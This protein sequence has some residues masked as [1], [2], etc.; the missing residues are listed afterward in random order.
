M[1][2]QTLM[3]SVIPLTN[4]SER[5]TIPILKLAFFVLVFIAVF[6]SL[7]SGLQEDP[8]VKN[9]YVQQAQAF[10]QGRLDLNQYF[11]DTAV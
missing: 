5:R 3:G 9:L 6:G 4:K 11:Y 8:G 7:W 10:L 2:I 1:S